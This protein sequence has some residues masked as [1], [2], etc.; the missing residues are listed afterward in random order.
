MSARAIHVSLGVKALCVR[1]LRTLAPGRCPPFWL[2]VF[3]ILVASPLWAQTFTPSASVGVGI[4]TSYQNVDPTGGNDLNQFALGHARIYLGGTIT[5]NISVMFNTDYNSTT[6][7]MGI[8]D[9]VGQFHISP[10]F[11]VWFGRFLPPSD[12]DNFTGPF[13]SNEWSVY[14]DGIQDGYAAVFQGRDNGAAYWGDFKAG[15]AK[16]K[17]SAGAFD[18]GSVDGNSDVIFAGRVQLDF[19]DPEGG[20]YLNSTY[21]GDK[22]LLALGLATQVQTNKTATTADFLMERKVRG[23]G[24]FTIESEFSRYNGFGGY[25][26][27]LHQERRGVFACLLP[28]SE[29]SRRRQ[30]RAARQVCGGRVHRWAH[31]SAGT[32]PELPAENHGSRL[33]LHHQAV[34]R[35]LDE[36]LQGH[37]LQRCKQRFL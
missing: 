26:A 17:V 15:I 16:I 36:L 1:V 34:R 9:A 12:R 32:A 4:Q 35:P 3:L 29:R 13:Y 14:T 21:Y 20:Y 10:G 22:N 7:S 2:A 19:W 25:N 28:H 31:N 6:N 11:N 5:P 8:L 27:E 30:V 37:P 33:R 23:G 18:G 24:A